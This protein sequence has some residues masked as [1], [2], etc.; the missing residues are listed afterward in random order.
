MNYHQ[1]LTIGTRADGTIKCT[2][3]TLY[4]EK[5][6][7]LFSIQH[8][9]AVRGIT[10]DNYDAS[11]VSA[12]QHGIITLQDGVWVDKDGLAIS[13]D[14]PLVEVSGTDS[15][16]KY[17]PCRLIDGAREVLIEKLKLAPKVVKFE[18]YQVWDDGTGKSILKKTCYYLSNEERKKWE[19]SGTDK[20]HYEI[21]TSNAINPRYQK[22]IDMMNNR[23]AVFYIKPAA[24]EW[25][26]TE[27]RDGGTI[28]TDRGT[29]TYHS[30]KVAKA[31]DELKKARA[32]LLGASATIIF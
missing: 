21:K 29:I 8:K 2:Y 26:V 23:N 5:G 10:Y 17:V 9:D 18:I 24:F 13:V 30:E 31:E 12:Q 7:Q 32:I 28:V 1:A 4:D 15:T 22:L 27:L 25:Q 19:N 14:V 6:Q 16:R 3:A 20:Y 11:V